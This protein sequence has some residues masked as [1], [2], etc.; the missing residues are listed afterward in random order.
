MV[1]TA[2]WHISKG[3]RLQIFFKTLFAFFIDQVKKNFTD[4]T[5]AENFDEILHSDLQVNKLRT[6]PLLLRL[7]VPLLAFLFCLRIQSL[8]YFDGEF[9]TGRQAKTDKRFD[10]VISIKCAR[11][12]IVPRYEQILCELNV[13]PHYVTVRPEIHVLRRPHLIKLV[14]LYPLLLLEPCNEGLCWIVFDP[15]FV[16][17]ADWLNPDLLLINLDRI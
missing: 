5:A 11:S 10:D 16:I 12:M 14:L 8:E 1:E 6:L 13:L 7:L 15:K 9:R 17:K 2:H 4:F 3:N